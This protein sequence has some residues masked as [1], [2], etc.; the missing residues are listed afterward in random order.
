[1]RAPLL[2]VAAVLLTA[3]P[4]PAQG[5]WSVLV[6][7]GAVGFS[8]AAKASVDDVSEPEGFEP[9]ATTRLRIGVERD[10]GKVAIRLGYG[11]AEMGL[12]SV[13][14]ARVILLPGFT[15]HEVAL[16][17]GYRLVTTKQ[18]ATVAGRIGPMVQLWEGPLIDDSRSRW[19]IQAGGTLEAPVAGHL[20]LIAD[21]S[22]GLAGSPFE[23]TDLDD[24]NI[25]YELTN[26]WTRELAVGLRYRF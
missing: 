18:G 9:S 16:H 13:G 12:G 6:A 23:A 3:A 1:V 4:L 5:A 14:D 10:L 11:Y 25:S 8:A 7:G 17:V 20:S 15:M 22:L 26:L 21:G 24:L 2:S 19:G